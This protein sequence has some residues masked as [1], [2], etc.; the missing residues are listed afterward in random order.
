M[1]RNFAA[2]AAA[3]AGFT[4][5]I[6]AGGELGATGG[7]SDTVFMLALTRASEVCISILSAAIV[8]SWTDFGA[9]SRRLTAQLAAISAEIAAGLGSAFSLSG[10][11]F[12]DTRPVQRDLVGRVIALDRVIDEALGESSNLRL[13]ASIL[14]GAI[15]GLFAALSGWRMA[16]VQLEQLPIDQRRREADAIQRHLP[17]ELKS[18]EAANW[19]GNPLRVRQALLATVRAL[20]SLTAAARPRCDCLLTRRLRR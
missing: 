8:L 14:Q 2:F 10:R 15:G 9:A 1:L 13:H 18:G 11:D 4:A 12:A 19:T 3:L 5:A 7:A 16:V 6:V 17:Q 20:T